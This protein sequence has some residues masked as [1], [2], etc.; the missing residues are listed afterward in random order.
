MTP[1]RIFSLA[2]G[3]A[4]LGWLMLVFAGRMRRVA[5]LVTAVMIPLTLA[6]LY[7]GLLAAHF[8]ES[9]GGFS[10]LAGVQ[11]LFSN[12]WLLLAGWVHYLCFDLFVGSWEV[13]DSI[14]HG[15]PHLIVIPCLFAT[16]MLGPSGL[17]L[18]MLI[19]GLKSK[20]LEVA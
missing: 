11:S 12:P 19:R 17:L 18:Y 20:T 4:L 14:K 10:T 16:F 13:R 5:T 2:N 6:C 7:V 8:G 9:T 3:F 15:I 1:E